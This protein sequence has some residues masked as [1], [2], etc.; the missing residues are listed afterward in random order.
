MNL[1]QTTKY[2]WLGQ[3]TRSRSQ[4]CLS[5]TCL[6]TFTYKIWRHWVLKQESSVIFKS[7]PLNLDPIDS[8]AFFCTR[9]NL[10]LKRIFHAIYNYSSIHSSW[11]L[12]FKI[13]SNA[14]PVKLWTPNP[15]TPHALVS[16]FVQAWICVSKWWFMPFILNVFQKLVLKKISVLL[17]F[18]MFNFGTLGD[19]F[20]DS[21]T[22]VCT[23]LYLHIIL[24]LHSEI[25]GSLKNFV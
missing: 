11:E 21:A 15:T 10:N 19:G 9:F 4:W 1:V 13:Y 6:S 8:G 17:N 18:H 14:T 3:H 25:A 24:M 20:I 2:F 22:S 5:Y 12:Y 7:C 16:L 23:N